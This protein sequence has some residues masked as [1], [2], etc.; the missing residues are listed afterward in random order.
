VLLTSLAWGPL[1]NVI[2]WHSYVING[3]KFVTK[4][5]NEGMSTT[6]CNLC[7]RGGQLDSLENDYYGVL[8][9]IVELEYTGHPTKKVVL[10]QCDW[11]DPSSQG[12]KTDNY[13]N[14]EIK[15][16]RKYQNYD[17]FILAQQ[18]DQVY[19]T[20]FPE[21]QQGWLGVIKTKARSNIQTVEKKQQTTDAY[22]DDDANTLPIVVS[23]DDFQQCLVDVNGVA[24][25]VPNSL[26][27]RSA[28]PIVEDDDDDEE[29]E[30]E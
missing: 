29:E 26:L 30:E 15:K 12:T 25:E 24:E 2:K 9:D 13:G 10:F 7:V 20:S 1:R 6:N 14:V 3:Y 11:F 17:P 28:K 22:Q 21:G 8:T 18:A 27:R 5:R 4:S 19:F 23:N 16:S